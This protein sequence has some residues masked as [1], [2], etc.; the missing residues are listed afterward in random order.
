MSAS[1]IK[2][3]T[4]LQVSFVNVLSFRGREV[5]KDLQE[6]RVDLDLLAHQDLLYVRGME[7]SKFFFCKILNC[8]MSS[9]SCHRDTWVKPENQD[10]R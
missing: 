1:L 5:T 8:S 4:I 7:F 6:N 9:T 2:N 3:K 10:P